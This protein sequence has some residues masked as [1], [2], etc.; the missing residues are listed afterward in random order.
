MIEVTSKGSPPPVWIHYRAWGAVV[1]LL[2]GVALCS[3]VAGFANAVVCGF[4]WMMLFIAGFRWR[5]VRWWLLGGSLSR[6]TTAASWTPGLL[7]GSA[8]LIFTARLLAG[9]H[10]MAVVSA[11]CVALGGFYSLAKLGCFVSGCCASKRARNGI[12]DRVPLPLA[13]AICS[14]LFMIPAIFLYQKQLLSAA[15]GLSVFTHLSLRRWSCKR[16]S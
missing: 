6:S 13:E 16:R 5:M 14:F 4:A 10:W 11:F 12:I 15:M 7:A 8:S 9:D 1:S 3:P 2:F